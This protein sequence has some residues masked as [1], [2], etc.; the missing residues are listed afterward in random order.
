MKI[1]FTGGGTGGHFYPIIA[2]AEAVHDSVRE[3]HL[4]EPR[5]YY[6]APEPFDAEALF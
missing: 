1:A 6:F 2:I 3:Q 5:L 4:L